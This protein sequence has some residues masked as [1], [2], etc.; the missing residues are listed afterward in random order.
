MATIKTVNPMI[1]AA[2]VTVAA[3]ADAD[4]DASSRCRAIPLVYTRHRLIPSVWTVAFTSGSACARR[5]RPASILQ[6]SSRNSRC[7]ASLLQESTRNVGNGRVVRLEYRHHSFNASTAVHDQWSATKHGNV[8]SSRM[9]DPELHHRSGRVNSA[10][11]CAQLSSVGQLK[12]QHHRSSAT[13]THLRGLRSPESRDTLLMP[14][15]SLAQH[16]PLPNLTLKRNANSAARWPSS[17]GPSA[18]FALAVRRATPLA[19]P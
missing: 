12:I 14:N 19:S 2:S 4:A 15:V 6:E 1:A 7:P 16:R 5:R 18:H 10:S 13:R 8:G 17:A 9:I 3:D 11:W